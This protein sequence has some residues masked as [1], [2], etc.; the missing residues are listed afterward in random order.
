M[1]H[2]EREQWRGR[3]VSEKTILGADPGLQMPQLKPRGADEQ[4]NWLL[5]EFW[6]HKA[7]GKNVSYFKPLSLGLVYEEAAASGTL[8]RLLSMLRSLVISE[9]TE[10]H[11]SSQPRWVTGPD[12][13]WWSLRLPCTKWAAEVGVVMGRGNPGDELQVCLSGQGN[14]TAALGLGLWKW[15]P[16]A[17]E[18]KD[19][20]FPGKH[21][22]RYQPQTAGFSYSASRP[23]RRPE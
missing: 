8:Q 16:G 15:C 2:G 6:T 21:Q 23:L 5:S 17:G 1:P 19:K 12:R 22:S 3:P 7:V 11:W 4:P 14:T 20:Y 10:S 18:L 9:V 13:R